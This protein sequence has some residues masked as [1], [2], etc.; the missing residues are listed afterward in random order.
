L[1]SLELREIDE[2]NKILE[3]LGC[4]KYDEMACCF[5]TRPLTYLSGKWFRNEIRL[6]AFPCRQR[7]L[8]ALLSICVAMVD[9][10]VLMDEPTAKNQ[11]QIGGRKALAMREQACFG[12]VKLTNYSLS[13]PLPHRDGQLT[14]P[15]CS[16]SQDGNI[17]GGNLIRKL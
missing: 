1:G 9:Y 2:D 17:R 16:T 11:A 12:T 13:Y 5:C 4:A 10:P 14:T 8:F 6:L 3:D 7:L 15:A